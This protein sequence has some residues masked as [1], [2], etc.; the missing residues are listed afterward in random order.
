MGN[1]KER[2]EISK[3]EYAIRIKWDVFLLPTGKDE[4]GDGLRFGFFN[5]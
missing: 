4:M 1:I 2:I 5:Y 3:N